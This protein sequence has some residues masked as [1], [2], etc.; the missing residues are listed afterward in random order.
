MVCYR[1]VDV[2]SG[3]HPE[4][5][6]CNELQHGDNTTVKEMKS[7]LVSGI[8]KIAPSVLT[9]LLNKTI[10]VR[11]KQ[12]YFIDKLRICAHTHIHMKA[13]TLW[14]WLTTSS[15]K[16]GQYN[17]SARRAELKI[18]YENLKVIHISKIHL[19][20]TLTEY[21]YPVVGLWKQQWYLWLSCIKSVLCTHW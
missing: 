18:T 19:S 17:R 20:S 1:C 7:D 12:R 5:L 2:V 16:R 11:T 15:I 14:H 8:N 3:A 10:T 4:C 6:Y 9:L 21:K 13:R